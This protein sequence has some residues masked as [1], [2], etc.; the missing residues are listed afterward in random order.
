MDLV[1]EEM[2][3]APVARLD[4]AAVQIKHLLYVFSG[5]ANIDEVVKSI[6]TSLRF[7]GPIHQE[8]VQFISQGESIHFYR[9]DGICKNP[10]GEKVTS[11][12]HLALLYLDTH[13]L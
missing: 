13:S 8:K 11:I 7:K 12:L 10:C 4:G 1:W 9:H 5:Y 6:S 3:E 2:A